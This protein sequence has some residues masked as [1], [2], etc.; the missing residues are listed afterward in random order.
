LNIPFNSSDEVQLFVA[1]SLNS[2][3]KKLIYF[4]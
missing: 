4:M 1:I 3:L 2:Y